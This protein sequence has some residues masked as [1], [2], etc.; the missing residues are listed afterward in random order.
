MRTVSLRWVEFAYCYA[1][2]LLAF[3]GMSIFVQVSG[4]GLFRQNKVLEKVIMAFLCHAVLDRELFFVALDSTE[5]GLAA[6]A[7]KHSALTGLWQSPTK[8]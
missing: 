3:F 1:P 5:V 4:A 6:T 8:L 7:K 2:S